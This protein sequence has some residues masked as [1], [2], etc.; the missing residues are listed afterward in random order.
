MWSY[1]FQLSSYDYVNMIFCQ[2][3]FVK[4]EHV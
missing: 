4:A 2:T 3:F 1:G